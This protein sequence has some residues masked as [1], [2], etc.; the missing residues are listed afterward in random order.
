MQMTRLEKRMVNRENKGR[1]N[2][3]LL[4]QQLAKIDNRKSHDILEIGCGFGY[5]SDYLSKEYR[6]NVT[7][8]DFDPEQI[9]G[10]L[11]LFAENEMLHFQTEDVA[12]LSFNDNSFDLVISQY[13]FHHIPEWRKAIGEVTRVLRSGGYFIWLILLHQL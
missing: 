11:N 9:K 13:V 1:N 7:G 4:S 6:M 3:K 8:T 12:G 5:V 10:A 2:I